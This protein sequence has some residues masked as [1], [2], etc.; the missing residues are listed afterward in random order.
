MIANS[1]SVTQE[2]AALAAKGQSI[3][4]A[5]SKVEGYRKSVDDLAQYLEARQDFMDT[6]YKTHFGADDDKSA[7]MVAPTAAEK[8]D[9]AGA[10]TAK[11]SM[12]PCLLYTSP[13]PRD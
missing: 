5:A 1:A 3:A 12:A 10:L 8:S 13:S 11:I 7:D 6:L 2:R 9:Q 4:T